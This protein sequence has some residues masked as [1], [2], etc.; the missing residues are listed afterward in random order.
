MRNR[1]VDVTGWFS[2]SESI[3]NYVEEKGVEHFLVLD[4]MPAEFPEGWASLVS[5]RGDS[6]LA[7]EVVRK[8]VSIFVCDKLN[9]ENVRGEA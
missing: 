4:D 3:V 1:I 8:R 5:C 7:D 6:G 2:R 9:D